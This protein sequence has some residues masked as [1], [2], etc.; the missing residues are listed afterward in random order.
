MGPDMWRKYLKPRLKTLF[1]AAKEMGKYV[2]IHTCGDIVGILPDIIEVGVDIYDPFQPEAFNVFELK[3][4][5]G[6]E[7]TFLGGVS[8][9]KVLPFGR[10]KDVREEV[11]Y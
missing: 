9:Q 8:R 1:G 5:Y 6:K 11:L 2:Y 10:V 7:I 4:Q 3:K